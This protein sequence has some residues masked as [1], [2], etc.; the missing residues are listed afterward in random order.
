MNNLL[1]KVVTL[2]RYKINCVSLTRLI[3]SYIQ[4][5]FCKFLNNA[6][7][8]ERIRFVGARLLIR[9]IG[10]RSKHF[11]CQE[12]LVSFVDPRKEGMK[13]EVFD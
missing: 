1:S 13:H 10:S 8:Q 4:K 6:L 7:R 5:M 11:C 2:F 12:L 3:C 9:V